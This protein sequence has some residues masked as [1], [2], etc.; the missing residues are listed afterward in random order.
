MGAPQRILPA[1]TALRPG[2][3][4]SGLPYFPLGDDHEIELVLVG[5]Q[6][7]VRVIAPV[8]PPPPEE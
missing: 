2:R 7:A 4:A 5:E 8:A 3:S 1:T 6:E